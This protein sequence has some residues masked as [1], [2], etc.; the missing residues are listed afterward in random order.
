ML[1]IAD[2]IHSLALVIAIGQ[3]AIVLAISFSG[4]QK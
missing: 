1:E 3:F 4:R 2:A